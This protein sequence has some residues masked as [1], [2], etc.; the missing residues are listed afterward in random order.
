MKDEVEDDDQDEVQHEEK[1]DS[2]NKIQ[3]YAANC[4]RSPAARTGSNPLRGQL[5]RGGGGGD[6][7]HMFL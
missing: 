4:S 1:H 2:V 3:R 5:W 7:L 6:M